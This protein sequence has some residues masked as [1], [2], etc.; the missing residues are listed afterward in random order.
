MDNFNDVVYPDD[1]NLDNVRLSELGDIPSLMEKTPEEEWVFVKARVGQ[2][3]S[4]IGGGEKI[5]RVLSS[6]V[7]PPLVED[8][9]EV[10]D[11]DDIID[12]MPRTPRKNYSYPSKHGEYVKVKEVIVDE[13]DNGRIESIDTSASFSTTIPI[14]FVYEV[15]SYDQV[16]IEL[17]DE[18]TS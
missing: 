9:T 8:G 4:M 7:G 18:E 5:C 3:D 11:L 16:I 1:D 14:E 6:K 12:K 17:L 13:Y 10:M 2:R 15:L